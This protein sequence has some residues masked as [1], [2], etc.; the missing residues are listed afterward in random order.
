[1][2]VPPSRSLRSPGWWS[3]LAVA[4]MLT[5]CPSSD[6]TD[7]DAHDSAVQGTDVPATGDAPR[8]GDASKS[9]D[10]GAAMDA[11]G[12]PDAATDLDATVQ[13]APIGDR[14][15][16][17]ACLAAAVVDINARGTLSG[18]VLRFVSDNRMAPRAPSLP[19][20]CVTSEVNEGQ[21][22]VVHRYVP[23][24][25]GRLRVSVDDPATDAHFDTVL[26]AQPDC[27]ALLA[28]ERSL[29][30]NNNVEASAAM[31]PRAST[32]VSGHVTAGAAV[33]LVLSGNFGEDPIVPQGA[34]ALSV[35]ELPEVAIDA[36]CDPGLR[37]N[38]CT[39]GASCLPSGTPPM[40]R[41][42]ADGRLDTRCRVDA[43]PDCD[44]GLRC[45]LNLCRTALAVGAPCSP[46]GSGVCAEGS[47][48]Q[49]RDGANTCLR[50]GSLGADC[51]DDAPPCD[52]GLA[53]V[54][55]RHGASCRTAVTRGGY[56]DPWGFRNACAPDSVCAF[57]SPAV[58]VA[59][60]SIAGAPC[61]P[62]PTRCAAGLEC[63]LGPDGEAE[64]CVSPV[65]P[66]G[67]CDPSGL[68]TRC[69]T[70]TDC[71]AG[72]TLAMGTCVAPGRAAGAPCQP[73]DLRCD[74]GLAC[75]VTSGAGQCQR[76]VAAG[77]ACDLRNGSTRCMGGGCVAESATAAVCRADTPEV[78]PNDAPATATAIA[79]PGVAVTG[80]L[81]ATDTR[82]CVRVT[83]PAGGSLVVETSTGDARRCAIAGGDPV[84]SVFG[85]SGAE[86][87]RDDDSPGRG[88]C[89]TFAPWTWPQASGLPAGAYV[90]C[91]GRGD[92]P[93]PRY[94]LTVAALP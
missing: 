40:P 17:P 31:R 12:D 37:A 39:V 55:T 47:V 80:S 9:D 66:G 64:L 38:A 11:P 70:N 16:P 87:A 56:C 3:A 13:D 89:N 28:G 77:A 7:P 29:G 57:V 92:A 60:G 36:A 91:V 2:P 83:V 15:V 67:A 51:R 1:M 63:A 86:I 22:Q 45:S 34:Y 33:F 61:G 50:S 74:P 42:A 90:V 72:A 26:S 71:A 41:C 30:C 76:D 10:L 25:A 68:T 81:A 85:P 43:D 84:L 59:P 73:V 14:P 75:S 46:S 52:T 20:T 21:Y 49:W 54:N 35:T 8:V 18:G 32:L 53:C 65:A 6:V 88:L 78:E 93:V 69:T 58:C 4:A 5:G 62:S 82:D 27:V 48:C 44:T 79:T 94:R 24:A 19:P 23:R